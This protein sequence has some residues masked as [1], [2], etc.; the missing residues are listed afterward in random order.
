MSATSKR[1]KSDKAPRARHQ[2]DAA[3]GVNELRS[4]VRGEFYT[5]VASKY[6]ST[7]LYQVSYHIQ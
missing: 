5:I 4:A 6:I 3:G 2:V 1:G 7:T